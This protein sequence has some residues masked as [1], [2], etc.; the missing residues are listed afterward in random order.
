MLYCLLWIVNI[1]AAATGR[2]ETAP[3]ARADRASGP[4]V[5]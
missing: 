2:S 4:R 1:Q 3:G 5:K